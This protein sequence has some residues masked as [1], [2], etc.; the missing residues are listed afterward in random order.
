M[1]KAYIKTPRTARYYSIG[2][3][4][5]PKKLWIALHGHGQQS[6]YFSKKLEPLLDGDTLVIVPEG[7]NR[8]YL[9]GYNGRVGATWMTSDDRQKDIEDN[10]EYLEGLLVHTLEN[11][12][13]IVEINTYA[14]S[15]GI[16]T[17]CRWYAHSKFDC[18]KLIFWAGSLANDLNYSAFA[19]KFNKSKISYVFGDNDEFF[20]ETKIIMNES[21]LIS[22]SIEYQ[23]VSFEGK[24]VIDAPLLKQ[25]AH[26]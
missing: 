24:H 6:K 5:N 9:Q 10:I 2:N 19:D 16:A 23:L 7:L 12:P 17:A 1:T 15:Q 13:S 25:L 4:K 21:L 14:F 20:D 8:Y 26:D 11:F 3:T 22:A 18:S